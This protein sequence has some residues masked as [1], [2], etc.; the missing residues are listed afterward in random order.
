MTKLRDDVDINLQ[1]LSAFV[2]KII[3]DKSRATQRSE[4]ER[5]SSKA[6][7]KLLSER[8][9]KEC[10]VALKEGN[11]GLSGILGAR[12]RG[13]GNE[14]T[15]RHNSVQTLS[16]YQNGWEQTNVQSKE[17]FRLVLCSTK[18][19]RCESV[20]GFRGLARLLQGIML[21][22]SSRS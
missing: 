7:W 10:C 8:R 3:L 12:G 6:E 20:N 9:Q 11:T 5:K 1:L 14:K 22:V 13:K 17:L 21:N 16:G 4:C 19:Q 15:S 2:L 18:C